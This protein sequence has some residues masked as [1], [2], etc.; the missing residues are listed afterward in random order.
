MGT[1]GPRRA[2]PPPAPAT[3]P[4][5]KNQS[6]QVGGEPDHKGPICPPLRKSPQFPDAP[7]TRSANND[8]R[9]R[10]RGR[11]LSNSGFSEFDRAMLRL[12]D[13]RNPGADIRARI[14]VIGQ[15]INRRFCRV[16]EDI[17]R[18]VSRDQRIRAT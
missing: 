1:A 2:S 15:N 5:D 4:I 7:T 16:H 3:G 17:Y 8:K 9:L 11:A 13:P 14:S 12:G 6:A 18:I 10:P